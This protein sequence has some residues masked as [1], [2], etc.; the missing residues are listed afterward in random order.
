MSP[1]KSA[2]NV[3]VCFIC[4]VENLEF[5]IKFLKIKETAE[6]ITCKNF[7]PLLNCVNRQST[8][9]SQ[10]E[11]KMGLIRNKYNHIGVMMIESIKS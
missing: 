7:Q 9:K 4:V 10:I 2:T 5:H 11:H 6:T 3:G 8:Y 1:I